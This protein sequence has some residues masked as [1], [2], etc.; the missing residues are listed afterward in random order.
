MINKIREALEQ[1]LRQWDF[2]RIEFDHEEK[3]LEAEEYESCEQA[4]TDLA[5]LDE[6]VESLKSE[7]FSARKVV[8]RIETEDRGKRIKEWEAARTKRLELEREMNQLDST[9]AANE[10]MG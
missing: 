2:Y 5:K 6:Y 3:D 10:E 7:C 9:S 4:L 8:L 1:A